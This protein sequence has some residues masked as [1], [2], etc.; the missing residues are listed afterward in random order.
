[1]TVVNDAITPARRATP[2]V[3]EPLR[4]GAERPH[5]DGV[6]GAALSAL[7]R[8]AG[9]APW[10][11]KLLR[12]LAIRATVWWSDELVGNVSCNARR[13]FGRE[14]SAAER[15]A[16]ARAVV[17]SFYD[18]IADLGRTARATA[19]DLPARMERVEGEPAYLAARRAGGG[20]VLV[21]AHMGSFEVGLAALRGVEGRVHV[22][23]KRDTF[24]AFDRIRSRCRAMLGVYEAPVDDGLTTLMN[25]RDA[26]RADEV[27]VMQGDRA[28][29]GQRSQVVP[30]LHGHLRLPIGPV[31]LARLTGS[32]LVPVV[33]VRAQGGRFRV[34]LCE[35]IRIDPAAPDADGVDPALLAVARAIEPFVARYPEQW[36]TLARAF[37]EDEAPVR[38]AAG[39]GVGAS[40]STD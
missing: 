16:F 10:L 29:P 31:K 33:V 13:I 36:L 20:A 15:R 27:V 5:A 23:F 11:L 21:T 24:P 6:T 40:R 8:A 12:P 32:P 17:G 28:M 3:V 38:N 7:F 30:F 25:L 22:V 18:F 37:V 35:P 9:S 26:L 34:H 39:S 2:F 4:A 14:P 1:M 19:D